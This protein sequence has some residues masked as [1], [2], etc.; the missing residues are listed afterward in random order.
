MNQEDL[1]HW[2][3]EYLRLRR[4]RRLLPSGWVQDTPGQYSRVIHMAY[5][6]GVYFAVDK[7]REASDPVDESNWVP[8]EGMHYV[9]AT[10]VSTAQKKAYFSGVPH[11]VRQVVWN[12]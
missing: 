5:P 10:A 6:N 12:G 3:C 2:A 9:E 11:R 7:L 8:L 1:P 4:D